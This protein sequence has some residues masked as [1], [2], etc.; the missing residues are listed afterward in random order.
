MSLTTILK[1]METNR[2]NAEMDVHLGT[3]TTYGGRVGLKW[4]ATE[5]LK[6]LKLDYRNELM[7][8]TVFIIVTGA[9]RDQFTELASNEAFGCFSTDPEELY[10][11]LASKINP[12][13]FGREGVRQLFNIAGN[14]LEDKALELD[15][16][17]YPMLQFNDKY[18]RAVGNVEDF[19][20]VIK[21]AINDQVGSEI[22]GI[23]AIHS[24]VDKAIGK[25]H[26]ALVT[27]LVLN[28]SDEKF[29]LDLQNNLKRL[30]PKV[31]LVAAGKASKD[32]NKTKD[33]VLV[34]TV[35]EESVGE[36]LGT[37]RSKILQ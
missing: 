28:T 33:V 5:T 4:A 25:N 27:P 1:E 32:L 7:A 29:A 30:T 12:T 37:I 3:E 6:R 34:K 26:A 9:G 10:K 2:P 18:N 15:I 22:V 17:S 31:F 19:A 21:S 11:D 24:I 23:N 36:A 20:S 35:S 8:S 14:L 16:D 13:L